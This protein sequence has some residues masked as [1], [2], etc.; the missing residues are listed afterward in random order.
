MEFIKFPKIPRMESVSLLITEKIDG[1]NAQVTVPE[2]P[3]ESL[4]VGSRNRWIT[5]GKT[6]DNF[7]FAQWVSEHEVAI[8]TLGPGTHY[9]EWWGPGIGRGYGVVDRRWSLFNVHRDNVPCCVGQVP[10]LYHRQWDMFNQD[11]AQELVEVLHHLQATGSVASPGFM[12]PEGVVVTM[13]GS[14]YKVIFDKA[15]PSPEES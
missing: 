9:G 14:L 8:R 1:T 12:R 13:A 2:D 11:T 4:L 3:D 5:P 6:T 7:G 10:V 15:G